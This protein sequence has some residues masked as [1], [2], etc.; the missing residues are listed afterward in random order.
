VGPRIPLPAFG[1]PFEKELS[2][3]LLYIPLMCQNKPPTL[4]H[5]K[6]QG[7]SGLRGTDRFTPASSYTTVRIVHIE[8]ANW[9]G[10][11]LS[12]NA[13]SNGTLE[14]TVTVTTG[15]TTK[16]LVTRPEGSDSEFWPM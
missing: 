8:R 16:K 7:R 3:R 5:E 9:H 10:R 15:E 11:T 14:A 6:S 1:L 12:L 2:S 4:I 13:T